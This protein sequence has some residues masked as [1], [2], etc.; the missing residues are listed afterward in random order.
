MNRG[1]TGSLLPVLILIELS[2]IGLGKRNVMV[3]KEVSHNRCRNTNAVIYTIRDGTALVIPARCKMWSCGYCA[4]KNRLHWRGHLMNRINQISLDENTPPMNWYFITITSSGGNRSASG[5]YTAL[6]SCWPTVSQLL[7][8]KNKHMGQKLSYV[9]VFEAHK[10]GTLHMHVIARMVSFGRAWRTEKGGK[11]SWRRLSDY[12]AG[13]NGVGWVCDV[14]KIESYDGVSDAVPVVGYVV[15]YLT[16]QSQSFEV[17]KG[18]R[19]VMTSRDMALSTTKKEGDEKWR[20]VG[21]FS[22]RDLFE[23]YKMGV[24]SVKN[25]SDGSEITYDYFQE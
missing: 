15:K 12:L 24:S 5:S 4:E 10:S 13:K 6:S 8:D 9:R 2:K 21:Y 19:R 23:L 17:P 3:E 20:Y 14:Q 22:D 11:R 25:L 16:K 18:G 7:R 1:V